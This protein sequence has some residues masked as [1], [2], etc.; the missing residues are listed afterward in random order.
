MGN[1]SLEAATK[2]LSNGR[3][4]NGAKSCSHYARRTRW[5]ERSKGNY[6]VI[7]AQRWGAL[8]IE[9]VLAPQRGI[10]D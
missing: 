1:G 5:S 3:N 8:R 6:F 10:N 7:I 9:R 2:L 4:L